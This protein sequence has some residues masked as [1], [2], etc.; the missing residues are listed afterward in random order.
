[1]EMAGATYPKQVKGENIL[2]LEGK[3]LVPVFQ[4]KTRIPHETLCWEWSGNRAIRQGKWKCVWD[5]L[6]GQWELYDVVA[7]RTETQ[8]LAQQDPERTEAMAAAW[9]KWARDT[10]ALK[11]KK[12]SKSKK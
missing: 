11:Q 9:T 3:S 12:S 6:V 7:D 4:G 5:K 2:P 8:D 10:G 1:M